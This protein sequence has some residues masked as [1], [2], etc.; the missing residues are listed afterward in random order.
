[1]LKGRLSMQIIRHTLPELSLDYPL[2]KL[3]P[4]EKILWLDIETTGL[5]PKNAC[6]YMIGCV[7]FRDGKYQTVQF[8]ADDVDEEE[9]VIYEF[10]NFASFFSVLITYNGNAFDIPFLSYRC[11][12]YDMPY[13]FDGFT[14]IDLYKRLRAYQGIFTLPDL[15]QKTV[16]ELMGISRT[17]DRSGHELIGIYAEYTVHPEEDLLHLLLQHNHDD[18]TGLLKL[19]PLLSFSDLFSTAA[20]RAEKAVRNQYKDY[21]GVQRS[22]LII[23]FSFPLEVPVPVSCGFSDL[24]LT[25]GGNRGKLRVAIYTGVLKHFYPDYMDYYYLPEEDRAVHKSVGTF[26][27]KNHRVQAKA[28]TCYTKKRGFFLPQWEEIITPVFYENY[29][30]HTMYFELTESVKNDPARFSRYA[31]HLL[32]LIVAHSSLKEA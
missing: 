23:E 8:M 27:D 17:D 30:D 20:V 13:R 14:G 2:E 24:Y 12:F 31:S 11:A 22:E 6:I 28:S 25:L 26:V 4:K 1:M 3:G 21:N 9:Q 16:E 10:F 18:I 32:K 19:T 15:K 5:S 29:R 7:Y